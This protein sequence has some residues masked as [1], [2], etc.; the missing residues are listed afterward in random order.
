MLAIICFMR[1]VNSIFQL[2][3][4]IMDLTAERVRRREQNPPLIEQPN[5]YQHQI[6]ALNRLVHGS[7]KH[8]HEQ[9]RVNR[10]VFMKLCHLLKQ[11]GLEDSRNVTLVERIAIFLWILSHHTKNRRTT[12]QFWR[13]GETISRHFNTVLLAV[14]RLHDVLWH[15]PQPIPA[16]EAD[17]RWKWFEVHVLII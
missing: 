17:T 13:S 11:R 8:C 16:N 10:H 3:M 2:Y 12:F 15:H 4:L 5:V 7:D 1:V 9:L 14:L 6:D